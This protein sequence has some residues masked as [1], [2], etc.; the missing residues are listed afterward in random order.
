M[1]KRVF[2]ILLA[3][4]GG[5]VVSMAHDFE[6][7]G[8]YYTIVSPERQTVMVV[9]P[10]SGMTYEGEMVIPESVRH[11][12]KSFQVTAI[13]KRTFQECTQL[14]SLPVPPSVMAIGDSAFWGCT[15][16]KYLVLK[17]NPRPLHIGSNM[18][19]GVS[20]GQALFYDCP[21]E[22]LYL[23]RELQYEG[24]FF[25]GYSPFY[26]KKELT[27]V[28]IGEGVHKLE[29][30]AFYGCES[31]TSVT[32]GG[33]VASVGNYAFY[34]C[35]SL[36]ELIVKEGSSP[37]E[38]GTNGKEKDLFS[39][40]P[41]EVL[42]LGRELRFPLPEVHLYNPFYKKESL[43]SV[44]LGDSVK[45]IR[46][47]AFWG[48]RSIVSLTVGG[49]VKRI[50]RS[51]FSRCISLRELFFKDGEGEL[52]L[53]ANLHTL[54]NRGEGLF[55]DSPV[56][57]LYLGRTLSYSPSYFDG[58]S[59]FYEQ[60]HLRSVVVGE[61]V[62]SL[63]DHLFGECKSL[64]KVTV[65]GAVEY[66]GNYSFKNCMALTEVELHDGV[67]PLH[68]GYN[69]FAS[70]GVGESLFSDCPLQRVYL[71]RTLSYNISRY[72]GFSP[73]Y[74]QK[75]LSSVV[76][77]DEVE[78]L[79][80]NI[81]YHCTALTEMV[82]P[83]GVSTIGNMAFMGCTSLR[84]LELQ[85]G[86]LPLSLGYNLFESK[87]QPL[88]YD[89]P[90]DTLY[91]GRDLHYLGGE[92]Y[93]FAP[94]SRSKALRQVVVGEQVTA[95]SDDLFRDC[96]ALS[97]V[98]I[99]SG[100]EKIGNRA[101]QGCGALSYLYFCDG[102]KPLSLGYTAYNPSGFGRSLFFDSPLEEIYIG[103]ELRYPEAIHYG[104]SP[105]YRKESLR[106]ATL[107]AGVAVAGARL[108]Y[109]CSRL[110]ELHIE[111]TLSKVGNYAFYGCPAKK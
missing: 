103:R 109:G 102:K 50:G 72:Y 58:Y 31:L 3:F 43:V 51:A 19:Y 97:S 30:R 12:G 81:F 92:T 11:A 93:G 21:L 41:I 60:T 25:Y 16:L 35:T 53:D 110:E 20:A 44:T 78:T 65:G 54:S 63:G 56:E 39:D 17:D 62:V 69:K 91:L 38:I 46:P 6:K 104:Y 10:P 82:I 48:C 89:A 34:A 9:A 57:T 61:R 79:P 7:E 68:V 66:I 64:A 55:S 5:L 15:G 49:N 87:G 29:N 28:V 26:K 98:I 76:I 101:F 59:P 36:K 67:K 8:I 84:R 13:D 73:F 23:G 33:A 106:K 24:G 52:F 90:I 99:G 18:Y 14:S 107:G 75:A 40:T 105:F 2:L 111:G 1:I 96:P 88:F 86:N 37:L 71:G 94:F 45:E 74:R 4:V 47:Y 42:Y 27:L 70:N 83:R 108:F 22:T 80:Q 77:G 95:I 85:D 32:I 100:V